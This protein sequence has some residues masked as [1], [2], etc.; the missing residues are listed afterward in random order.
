[1]TE[2]PTKALLARTEILLTGTEILPTETKAVFAGTE[3]LLTE[4]NAVFAGTETLPV[5]NKAVPTRFWRDCTA[6]KRHRTE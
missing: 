6:S 3:A 1:M 2:S 5:G 4:A